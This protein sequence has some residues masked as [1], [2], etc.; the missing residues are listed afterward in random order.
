MST[1][2][3]SDQ[4][5][6]IKHFVDKSTG[7]LA[8][9]ALAGCGKTS[10]LVWIAK[11]LPPSASKIFCAFNADIVQELQSKLIGTNVTARTFHSLG[12]AALKKYLNATE[13]KPKDSKYRDL[14]NKWADSDGVLSLTLAEVIQSYKA[15]ERADKLYLLRKE[16]LALFVD[17]LNLARVKLIEW[18]DIAGLTR[19]VYLNR[20]DVEVPHEELVDLVIRNVEYIMKQAEA[21]TRKHIIDFTDMIYWAVR[22]NLT[23]YPYKY[24][25]VDEA[26]DFNPMQRE[27]IAKI[28]DPK[29]GRIILVG[30]PNQAIYAFAGADSDSFDLS[31]KRWNC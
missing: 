1:F 31:V 18:N 11:H 23:L 10:T 12:L 28:I 9:A 16:T 21:E 17:L 24:V 14:V 6:A 4:Q 25:L 15:E 8:I 29:G 30:D 13:L 5:Q 3:P 20:L 2:V 22:W 26:Q 7:N 19:L 27:M